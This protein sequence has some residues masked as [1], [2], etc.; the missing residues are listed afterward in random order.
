MSNFF[1][2]AAGLAGN[3]GLSAASPWPVS[4]I[5]TTGNPGDTLFLNDNDIL[6][7]FTYAR[8]GTAGSPI[9]FDRYGSGH[10]PRIDAGAAATPAIT[11]NA[12]FI[13]LNNLYLKNS[14]S[15]NGLLYITTG[16]H[17]ITLNNVAFGAGIRGINAFKMGTA[18]VVNLLVSHCWFFDIF[19]DLK[20]GGTPG[21]GGA[22][23]TKNGGGSHIQMNGC[24]GSGIEIAN[25]KFYT[26]DPSAANNN[27][28]GVG[29]IISPFQCNGTAASRLWVHDNQIRGGSNNQVT[30][31]IGIT[32]ADVGGSYQLVENNILVNPGQGGIG[33]MPSGGIFITIQN[34]RMYSK[35]TGNA[36]NF[37]GL[38]YNSSPGVANCILQNNHITYYAT[39]HAPNPYNK[40]AFQGP[41]AG[42]NTNTADGAVDTLA[43]ETM[44]PDP[45]FNEFDWDLAAT[46]LVFN[47]LTAKTYGNA[48][49]SPGAT[50][51][52][53]ITYTSSNL[54]VA[55]IVSGQIHIVAAGTSTITANDGTSSISQLLTVNK[56]PLTVTANAASKTY[57]AANP[58]LSAVIAG[59]VLGESGTALTTQ[60]A[61][62]T[63]A[64][65]G[66]NAGTYPITPSGGAATNYSFVYVAA[67]LTVN[68]AALTITGNN[69]S[70][71]YAVANPAFGVTYAG[72]VNGNNAA[73]LTTQPTISTPATISSN[74]GTYAITPVGAASP[75]YNISYVAGTLTVNKV[76]LTITANNV[77]RQFN[78]VNPVLTVSFAG[79]VNGNTNASLTAQPV[80]STTAVLSSPIGNYPITASGAASPNYTFTY[81]PGTMTVSANSIVFGPISPKT[82]GDADFG[83][84]ASSSTAITYTSSNLAVATIVGGLVH[85]VGAG[86][87]NITANNGTT[88]LTQPLTVNPAPLTIT[89]DSHVIFVGNTIPFLGVTY[90]GFVN[91]DTSSVLTSIPVVTT[92]AI[93]GSPI[94]VYSIDVTGAAASN[95]AMNYVSG[96]LSIVPPGS[97]IHC[98]QP[99]ILLT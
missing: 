62:T 41:P 68:K 99:V 33:V 38:T 93:L 59:Y 90:A 73:S 19:D 3:T 78:T 56:V 5:P 97:K 64:V 81:V 15:P 13:T 84:G 4:K 23:D 88:T 83:A 44:L 54:A 79:F 10:N 6:P 35:N 72:F 75:N 80:P 25:S 55:T 92:A 31:Y 46:G 50:S 16:H 37:V 7:S 42:W 82:Y 17:D 63:T 39:A 85:I 65:T 96:N 52:N 18:G 87:T 61:V 70:R 40:F 60:P 30:G 24:N 48:N 98:S 14:R 43:T 27:N 26:K 71:N 29:D 36:F 45:L 8:S 12:N 9:T 57:G 1:F 49:F 66:S 32:T 95:Y 53:A 67:V 51:P 77:T 21:A 89:A 86:S 11:L 47:P 94:G 20:T 2:A 22:G 76:N 74:A 28:F 91:G 34:N 69:A 58:A